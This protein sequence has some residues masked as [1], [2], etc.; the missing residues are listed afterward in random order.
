MWSNVTV[1]FTCYLSVFVTYTGLQVLR[2]TMSRQGKF[3]LVFTT[4]PSAVDIFPREELLG[5]CQRVEENAVVKGI[6]KKSWRT[7]VDGV[8]LKTGKLLSP[9]I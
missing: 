7:E 1:L 3:A 9:Q 2:P 8:I 4:N 5:K 6:Q